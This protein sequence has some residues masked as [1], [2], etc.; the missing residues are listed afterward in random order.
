MID[1]AQINK[2]ALNRA[3]VIKWNAV[4]K[5]R[6]KP[7]LAI[8]TPNWL[9]VDRAIIFF[10]SHSVIADRPAISIVKHAIKS[11]VELN[12]GARERNG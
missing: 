4:N 10:K 12:H 3:C 7:R 11:R 9:K 6:A 8:I 2:S 1:P 5:G